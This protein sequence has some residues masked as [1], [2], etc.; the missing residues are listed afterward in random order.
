V[1]PTVN[2]R[3][4]QAWTLLGTEGFPAISVPAGFTTQ[5][6]DRVRDASA[7]GET[8]LVGPFPAQLPVGM[9][10]LGRPFAEP[11]LLKIA[12]AYEAATHHRVP[13][14]AFGPVPG[15]P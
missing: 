10:I 3:S 6:F 5:V 2:D 13:P 12:S 1:E 4:N 9:D 7:P 8:V 11:T 15:E 14:A